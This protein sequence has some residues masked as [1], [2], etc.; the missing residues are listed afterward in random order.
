MTDETL[1]PEQQTQ[2]ETAP[3]KPC[4]GEEVLLAG[5]YNSVEALEN[6]YKEL[7]RL[8][9][10]KTP[11]AEAPE[12]P[13]AYEVDFSDMPE[14]ESMALEGDPLWQHITPVM[15]KAALTQPQA[16][17]L[18]KA[19]VK[20]QVDQAKAE[21]EVFE[22]MGPEGRAMAQQV[23]HFI[24]K[25]FDGPDVELAHALSSSVDGLKFLQKIATM[26]GEKQV[27]ASA[28]GEVQG[29]ASLKEKALK[30]LNDPDLAHNPEKQEAYNRL[31]KSISGN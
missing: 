8:V 30:M 14:L 28:L 31:W 11:A 6:G 18:T 10:E 5:K 22:T 24:D 29:V 2:A 4:A 17:A 16:E 1:N 25:T 26:A 20:F 21:Q 3:E 27:P 12:V 15:Q 13:E 23:S 9:R 19:F 7:S